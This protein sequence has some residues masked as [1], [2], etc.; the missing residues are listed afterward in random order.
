MRRGRRFIVM[1]LTLAVAVV[2]CSE[3]ADRS[4][5]PRGGTMVFATFGDPPSLDPQTNDAS[6]LVGARLFETLVELEPGT[7]TPRPRLARSWETVDGRVWTFRLQRD[8]NFH[9][10]TPFDAAAVCFNFERWYNFKGVLQAISYWLLAFEGFATAEGGG[11]P[12][13]SLYQ[14]CDARADDEVVLTLTRP[15]ANL[16]LGLTIPAFAMASPDALRRY[17]ADRVSGTKESPRFEGSFGTEHPVGTGPFRFGSWQRNDRLT[18]VR[19]E[20]YWGDRP[21]LDQVVFQP[22]PDPAARRS[23]LESG[24]IDGYFAVAAADLE[25]L[26]RSRFHILEAPAANVGCL[27]LNRSRPPLDRVEVRQAIAAAVNREAVVKAFFPPGTDVATQFLPPSMRGH[28]GEALSRYDP[29]R[30][31]VLVER[32]G[33]A[34]PTLEL[35]YPAGGAAVG[36]PLVPDPEALFLAF[37]A[38]LE[39]VGFRVVGRPVGPTE[40]QALLVGGEAQA[41]LMGF[42][43]T[44]GEPEDLLRLFKAPSPIAGTESTE[45]SQM[46]DQATAELD[47]ARQTALYQA[48]NRYVT[49]D[50]VGAVAYAHV[51]PTAA[52]DQAVE[53]LRLGIVPYQFTFESAAIRGGD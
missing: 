29:D 9:D 53:G 15:Y 49:T 25:P 1:T 13:P 2:A 46:L 23:A 17:E 47:P 33:V 24:E 16:P 34:D 50:L 10:G 42:Y 30:A 20:R 19:N 18:V 27:L 45:V 35:A 7:A 44:R 3:N 31:R 32:S 41:I 6:W 22:I 5:A 28:V 11:P 39:R 4:S 8:V 51:K 14:S 52:L 37:K 38:D 12:R 40:I 26:R 21:R 43:S 36:H 48:A